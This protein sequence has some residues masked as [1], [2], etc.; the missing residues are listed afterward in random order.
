MY[1]RA[2]SMWI[3]AGICCMSTA[4]FIQNLVLAHCWPAPELKCWFVQYIKQPGFRSTAVF[5]SS[6]WFL[7]LLHATKSLKNHCSLPSHCSQWGNAAFS[8][9]NSAL[10][11]LV[12]FCVTE[13]EVLAPLGSEDLEEELH[14]IGEAQHCLETLNV[15][16]G[17]TLKQIE[18]SQFFLTLCYF[19]CNI[20]CTGITSSSVMDSGNS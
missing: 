5:C 11:H 7:Y 13:G 20:R 10:W 4:V 16:I 14:N 18:L 17:T 2:V 8:P 6:S 9:A 19:S 1:Y 3:Q 15:R 12:C